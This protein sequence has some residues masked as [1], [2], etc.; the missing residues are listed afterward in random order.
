M[1]F[2]TSF[3]NQ[4]HNSVA[5]QSPPNRYLQHSGI[6]PTS[7]LES[8]LQRTILT[9]E[10]DQNVVQS[11][12][13]ILQSECQKRNSVLRC[14]LFCLP[15]YSGRNWEWR[16]QSRLTRRRL[17]AALSKRGRQPFV[18]SLSYR[19]DRF[20]WLCKCKFDEWFD[21][22]GRVSLWVGIIHQQKR[23]CV[24]SQCKCQRFVKIFECPLYLEL[25]TILLN[26]EDTNILHSSSTEQNL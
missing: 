3:Q 25:V 26:W 9:N 8:H 22:W 11:Q 21:Y 19:P 24:S 5:H 18:A 12:S 23:I 6:M 1:F 10:L 15:T 20:F 4:L 7:W 17:R 13:H 14:P 16:F 2:S